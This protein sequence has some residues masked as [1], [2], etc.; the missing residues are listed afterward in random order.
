[1]KKYIT[2]ILLIFI[3]LNALSQDFGGE[4]VGIGNF[5]RR[6]YNT[7]PFDGI[8]ILQNQEGQDYMISVIQLKNDFSRPKNIETRIA[9]I[10]AKA[11]VSQYINGSII[12][13]DV[14]IM[15][16]ET[17]SKDSIVK[18][19]NILEILKESSIGF[20]EGMEM[21]SSFESIDGKFI[22]Y[23]FYKEIKK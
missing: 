12:S 22:I 19:T 7:Q 14:I 11:F 5:V 9:S 17:K 6:I 23:M 8:K 3:C 10:K 2:S 13:S 21:L 20:V 4:K 16:S 18:K 1:M 15:S